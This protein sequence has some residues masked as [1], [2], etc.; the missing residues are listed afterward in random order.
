VRDWVEK[1]NAPGE[2]V[3]FTLDLAGG[4]TVQYVVKAST[5]KYSGTNL[6]WEHP[7]GAD[8]GASS[9]AITLLDFCLNCPGGKCDPIPPPSPPCDNPD[10]CGGGGSGSPDPGPLY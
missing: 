4:S 6:K 2:Y 8:G 5:E 7:N 3:G 10:G 9:P 1:T